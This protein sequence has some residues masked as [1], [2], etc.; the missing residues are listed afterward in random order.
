VIFFFPYISESIRYSIHLALFA[1]LLRVSICLF[2]K[3][4]LSVRPFP[5]SGL[6]MSSTSIEVSVATYHRVFVE[7]HALPCLLLAS[8]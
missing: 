8:G 6:S 3:P 7:A 4:A 5:S 1:A 2:P